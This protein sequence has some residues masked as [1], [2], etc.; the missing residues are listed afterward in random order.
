MYRTNVY[1]YKDIL[2]LY[3]IFSKHKGYNSVPNKVIRA[4]LLR[5]YSQPQGWLYLAIVS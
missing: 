2:S 4:S 1:V 3:T 5:A